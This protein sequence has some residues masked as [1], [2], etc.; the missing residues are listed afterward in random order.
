MIMVQTLPVL[1]DLYLADETAWLDSMADLIRSGAH[2][3]LDYAN[4]REYLQDMAG[5]DRREVES[6]LEQ[7][8]LHIL[9]W[10]YEPEKRTRSWRVSINQQK[11]ELNRHASRGVLRNHAESCLSNAYLAALE[12]TA[13]ETGLPEETFPPEC[14]YALDELLA[15]KV[16]E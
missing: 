10:E 2:S 1:S 5:R 9:K 6:R 14:P 7:F 3:E 11:R 8:L 15:Y 16:A 13:T 4:L 12:D